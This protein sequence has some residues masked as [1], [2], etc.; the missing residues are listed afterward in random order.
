MSQRLSQTGGMSDQSHDQSAVPDDM[1]KRQRSKN[2]AEV[3]SLRPVHEP[4]THWD[5]D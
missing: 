1:R 5:Y 2:Q 4:A 3:W